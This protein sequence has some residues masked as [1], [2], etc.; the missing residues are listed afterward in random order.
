MLNWSIHFPPLAPWSER[1]IYYWHR[2]TKGRLLQFVNYVLFCDQQQENKLLKREKNPSSGPSGR[3]AASVYRKR[4]SH[5]FK[6]R[7]GWFLV[8]FVS[9]ISTHWLWGAPAEQLDLAGPQQHFHTCRWKMRKPSG[10]E[11][12]GSVLTDDDL[13]PNWIMWWFQMLCTWLICPFLVFKNSCI[14]VLEDC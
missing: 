12:R 5:L 3:G 4:W 14:N 9:F 2:G 7:I 6:G 13:L 1:N 11:V 10:E 8:G